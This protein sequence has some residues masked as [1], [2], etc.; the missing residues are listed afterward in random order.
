MAGDWIKM[1]TDLQTDPRVVTLAAQ[2]KR[3][4]LETVGALHAFWS[5]ADTHS[6]DGE[7]P[8]YTPNALDE[9]IR[10]DGFTVA[11]AS[12]NWIEIRDNALVLPDFDKHNGQSAKRRAQAMER[13]RVARE[14]SQDAN[15]SAT[16]DRGRERERENT[17]KQAPPPTNTPTTANYPPTVCL[18]DFSFRDEVEEHCQKRLA[19]L[20]RNKRP[21][22][23][24]GAVRSISRNIRCTPERVEWAIAAFKQTIEKRKPPKNAAAYIRSLIEG[25]SGPSPQVYPNRKETA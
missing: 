3:N 24:A 23:D 20:T 16:R 12:V 19:G 25:D 17:N 5:L 13:M 1:R 4:R 11:L 2:L 6:V 22:F 7:L 15:T 10:I 18:S 14:A 21:M 8:G 9:M